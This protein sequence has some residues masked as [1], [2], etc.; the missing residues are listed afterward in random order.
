[1]NELLA[2]MT[3]EELEAAKRGFQESKRWDTRSGGD[4]AAHARRF[5]NAEI[6]AVNRELRARKANRHAND[7]WRF[8][9]VTDENA[10][11]DEDWHDLRQTERD[12]RM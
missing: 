8:P 6:A 12:A 10:Q 7:G 4:G 1:M 5:Y 3:I 11:R 2:A 9:G